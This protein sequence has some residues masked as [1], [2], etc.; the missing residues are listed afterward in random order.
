VV[1][2]QG[3]NGSAVARARQALA[4]LRAVNRSTSPHR[5]GIDGVGRPKRGA[6]SGLV[7]AS[8]D[9]YMVHGQLDVLGAHLAQWDRGP[10]SN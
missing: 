4:K 5:N 10:S 9:I 8:L 2:Q 7:E 3:N 1:P 6:T